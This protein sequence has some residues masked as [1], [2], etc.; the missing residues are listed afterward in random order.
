MPFKNRCPKAF[1]TLIVTTEWQRGVPCISERDT[2][3]QWVNAFSMAMVLA[4]GRHEAKRLTS[5]QKGQLAPESHSVPSPDS[6]GDSEERPLQPTHHPACSWEAPAVGASRKRKEGG[7]GRNKLSWQDVHTSQDAP[8]LPS[9]PHSP[10]SI[11]VLNK[12]L[13]MI[14]LKT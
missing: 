13:K 2:W 3:G 12:T 6:A 5:G 10:S 9:I 14:F 8:S 4:Q 1:L 11:Q 7:R